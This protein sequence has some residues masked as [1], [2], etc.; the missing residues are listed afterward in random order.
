VIESVL[1]QLDRAPLQVA[2]QA[3]IA[4]VTLNNSLQYGVQYFLQ[5]ADQGSL[6][7]TTQSSLPIGNVLPG[8]N[9]LLGSQTSPNI[10]LSALKN[11]TNVRV[12]S[13]PSVVALDNQVASIQVG[14]Q[15]PVSTSQSTLVSSAT[16]GGLLGT[17]AYPT[18]NTIS[19]LNTG[20]ILHVLPR[21]NA[22]GNVTIDIDQEISNVVNNGSQNTLTPT[23]SQRHVKS[24]ISV[25]T[26]QTVMLAGL[27]SNS[28]NNGKQGIP[29]LS[30]IQFIGDLFATNNNALNRTELI[31]FIK[32]QIIAD[33]VDAQA[34]AEQMRNKMLYGGSFR[35]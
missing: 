20:V 14:D 4:E 15:V 5:H 29:I 18:T 9:F 33:N 31:I 6:S 17:P 21:I 32:P 2:I 34:V 27:I 7:L 35:R 28:V 23:V 26:G 24:S 13:T 12:L 10:V 22:N 16:S 25:A 11:T 30:D 3:T 8:F 19:Y 1:A